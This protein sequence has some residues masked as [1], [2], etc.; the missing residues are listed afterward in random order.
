MLF[1]RGQGAKLTD[2]VNEAEQNQNIDLKKAKQK[3]EAMRTL[4]Y[5]LEGQMK[6][7]ELE[8]NTMIFEEEVEATKKV[9]KEKMDPTLIVN[10]LTAQEEKRFQVML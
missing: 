2:Q 1:K 5:D 10:T 9:E 3:T 6:M 8:E 4:Y 7:L